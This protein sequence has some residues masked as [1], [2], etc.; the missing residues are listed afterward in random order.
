M[1]GIFG[2]LILAIGLLYAEFHSGSLNI[3]TAGALI[4]GGASLSALDIG[5]VICRLKNASRLSRLLRARWKDI[6]EAFDREFPDTASRGAPLYKGK[7]VCTILEDEK[8][9]FFLTRSAQG[10]KKVVYFS[11]SRAIADKLLNEADKEGYTLVAAQGFFNQEVGEE[12]V[13]D[14]SDLKVNLDNKKIN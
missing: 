10:K 11:P 7:N 9:A 4:G 3:A 8:I 5:F 14:Y 1:G 13:A 12:A 6:R 2:S